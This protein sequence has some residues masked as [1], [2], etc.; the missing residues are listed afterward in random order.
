MSWKSSVGRNNPTHRD[1]QV[2]FLC[3]FLIDLDM[4][5]WRVGALKV[6][7]DE[8]QRMQACTKPSIFGFQPGTFWLWPWPWQGGDP[9]PGTSIYTSLENKLNIEINM[10]KKTTSPLQ[11]WIQED[12][13]TKT[14]LEFL[15][16]AFGIAELSTLTQHT[17]NPLRSIH[18]S[19]SSRGYYLSEV[20][21]GNQQPTNH[22]NQHRRS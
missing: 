1:L 8:S 16:D 11:K 10:H 3:F 14:L 17:E 18:F 2:Q 5:N 4:V 7:L 19:W 9:E 22:N 13:K 15:A 20:S 12:F 21:P 6:K